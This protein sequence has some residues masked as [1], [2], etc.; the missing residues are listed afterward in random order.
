MP[1]SPKIL[2]N[3]PATSTKPLVTREMA[4]AQVKA[5]Q[6]QFREWLSRQKTK[7]G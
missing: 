6:K 2:P 4:E 7:E 3:R 5:G 1:N